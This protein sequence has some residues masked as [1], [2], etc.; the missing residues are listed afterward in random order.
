VEVL[1]LTV[2]VREAS[3][4]DFLA[5]AQRE[6]EVAKKLGGCRATSLIAAIQGVQAAAVETLRDQFSVQ[7]TPSLDAGRAK[8]GQLSQTQTKSPDLH[9]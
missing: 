9:D 1:R 6:G 8:R 2:R 3:R 5:V 7:R 4:R